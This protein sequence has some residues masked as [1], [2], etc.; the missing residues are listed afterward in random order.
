MK[1]FAWR[2]SGENHVIAE[3][4][5]CSPWS[6]FAL[7][8]SKLLFLY[9]SLGLFNFLY[10]T[11]EKNVGNL[12]WIE[13]NLG[14]SWT[15]SPRKFLSILFL[16]TYSILRMANEESILKTRWSSGVRH[17]GFWIIIVF[18]VLHA[19]NCKCGIVQIMKLEWKTRQTFYNCV[20]HKW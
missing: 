4:A 7:Q 3:S 13:E 9:V 11:E 10:I 16:F 8:F 12:V 17:K 5:E 15:D 6:D 14:F 2:W 1:T 19:Y 18:L 20:V